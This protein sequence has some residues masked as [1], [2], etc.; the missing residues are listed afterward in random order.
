MASS[1]PAKGLPK[2]TEKDK[3]ASKGPSGQGKKSLAKGAS[4]LG[5]VQD[6][7]KVLSEEDEDKQLDS[8]LET[9][10]TEVTQPEKTRVEQTASVEC[11]YCGEVFELHVATDEEGQ[12][13]SE[14]C[15]VCSRVISIHIQMEDDELQVEAYRGA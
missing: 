8:R 7:K 15:P 9:V 13:L 2:K 12:V 3:P 6:V 10:L 14:D 5:A 4:R 11:P 1:K